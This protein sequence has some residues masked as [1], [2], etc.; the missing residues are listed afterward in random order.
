MGSAFVTNIKDLAALVFESLRLPVLLPTLMFVLANMM[1]VFPGLR[2][3]YIGQFYY[4]LDQT[5]QALVA[6]ILTAFIAYLLNVLN[7]F[8][9]RWL[10]GYP[11]MEMP[12]RP[13]RV[14]CHIHRSH[15]LALKQKRRDLE[16]RFGP[17]NVESTHQLVS[18]EQLKLA[19]EYRSVLTE[20]QLFFPKKRDRI[21][22]TRFGNVI[23]AAEDHPHEL[24][25]MD[26]VTLWPLLVPIL[27][28][29]G[30]AKFI[31]RE[32][33]P[34]DF[35]VNSM[36]LFCT[37]G[38]ETVIISILH[39][40][41]W[42]IIAMQLLATVIALMILY[43]LGIDGALGWG[44]T[45]RTSFDLYRDHLR[46]SLRIKRPDSFGQERRHWGLASRFYA[47]GGAF[48][49]NEIFD[50]SPEAFEAQLGSESQKE[51]ENKASE[52]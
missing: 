30:Y 19:D 41:S 28:E 10:E 21:T 4:S 18:Q 32:K 11:L 2:D 42:L 50:Y 39:Q 7:L 13:G 24:Y 23:A 36:V 46:Q 20:L 25:N 43:Q 3:T 51:T 48:Q 37:L 35:I 26:S 12:L 52:E 8:L 17:R 22:P 44:F 27:T 16:E 47:M 15:F 9:I 49:G 34:L 6:A 5:S 14:F 45:I 31:E 40:R 29:K 33:A 1:I 38:I